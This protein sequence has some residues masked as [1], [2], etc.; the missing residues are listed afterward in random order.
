MSKK[1]EYTLRR[2]AVGFILRQHAGAV[3]LLTHSFAHDPDIPWRVPG[4][5]VDKGETPEEA[6]MREIAEETGLQELTIL[7]K[8]GVHTYY[9]PYVRANVE[10]HDFLLS[11]GNL[12]PDTWK[13]EVVGKGQDAGETFIYHWLSTDKLERLSDELR[14]FVTPGHI[15]ELFQVPGPGKGFTVTERVV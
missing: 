2:V 14:T 10:R 3:Q 15:P 4:G 6:L 1:Q 5:G 11:T 9:K 7:R 13:W 8:L 12:L